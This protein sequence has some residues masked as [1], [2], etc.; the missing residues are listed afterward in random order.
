MALPVYFTEWHLE[1]CESIYLFIFCILLPLKDSNTVRANTDTDL[2]PLYSQ[3]LEHIL[4]YS[5]S[6]YMGW[7]YEWVQ[8]SGGECKNKVSI[9]MHSL[10][11]N[12]NL[13]GPLKS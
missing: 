8:S 2:F 9:M 1:L 13:L 11:L 10:P 5:E 7:V 12:T 4:S 6:S 3:D